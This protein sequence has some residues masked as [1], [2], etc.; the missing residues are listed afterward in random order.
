MNQHRSP[1]DPQPHRHCSLQTRTYWQGGHWQGCDRSDQHCDCCRSCVVKDGRS[2]NDPHHYENLIFCGACMGNLA[3]NGKV[4]RPYRHLKEAEDMS[5]EDWEERDTLIKNLPERIRNAMTSA[6][7]FQHTQA[8]TR[9][10]RLTG[11]Q[12]KEM[13]SSAAEVMFGFIHPA[14]LGDTLAERLYLPWDI[15]QS[16]S[17]DIHR[18]VFRSIRRELE[19]M[20]GSF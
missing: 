4:T 17:A 3:Q 19:A 7:T 2:F 6:K 11:F 9:K 5:E 16:I 15:C 20:H 18:Q 13:C 10:Y 8:I 12:S 1:R 14:N